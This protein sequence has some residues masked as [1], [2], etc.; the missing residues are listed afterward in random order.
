MAANIGDAGRQAYDL[1]VVMDATG[2]MSSYIKALNKSLPQILGM[3][4]LTDCFQRIGVIA[5]RDYCVN[6]PKDLT[7]WSGWCSPS[8]SYSG[9]EIVPQEKV[10]AMVRQIRTIGSSDW[11][12][13]TKTGLAFAYSKMRPSATTIVL[14]YTDAPPHLQSVGGP[15]CPVEIRTLSEPHSYRR[16]GHLFVDWTSVA[17]TLKSG[18]KKGV[19]FSFLEHGRRYPRLESLPILV[20]AD[21]RILFFC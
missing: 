1:L 18:P 13:A 6:N 20:D 17:T 9:P 14:L 2:S 10:I 5:Y 4:A 21:R 7:E 8:G 16:A 19:V 12:E 3:A 15:N 11:D